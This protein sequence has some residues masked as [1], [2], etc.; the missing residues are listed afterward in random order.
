[1][2]GLSSPRILFGVHS[3]TPYN[4]NTGAPYG[5]LKVI[6]QCNIA[7]QAS[8]E[9]L[10][11]GAQRFA[12]ASESKTIDTTV[13]AKVKAFPGFLFAQFLGATVTDNAGEATASV[14]TALANV[15]GTSVL[16]AVTG[17]ASIAVISG[18]EKDVKFG[19]YL[20]VAT[21]ATHVDVYAYTDVDFSRNTSKT[22]QTDLLKISASPLAVTTGGTLTALTGFGIDVVGGSGTIAMTTGDTAVF[23][24]RPENTGS[25][26]III[27]NA[28]T[29][30]AAFGA[31]MLSQKRS[32]GEM[33]E[34][35]AF[36]CVPTGFPIPMD[37][38]KFAETE[39]K[40]DCIYDSTNDAV[41]KVHTVA[42]SF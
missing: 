21:D 23:Y 19:K 22:Y 18:S 30:M 29:Q 14:S 1:M 26:D 37:E 34:V 32:T 16:A 33:F 2:S 24:L 13:T 10:Y 42:P 35:E 20:L 39:L 36:N 40:M 11:A 4:R 27:G 31:V 7:L 12:W 3:M 17:V 25:T 28:T 38:M 41:F 6:G 5:I 15:Q 9:K 8:T